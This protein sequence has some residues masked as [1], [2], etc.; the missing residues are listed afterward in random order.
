MATRP[1]ELAAGQGVKYYVDEDELVIHVDL[2]S[3]GVRSA[4]GKTVVIASSRGNVEV[5]P[6][7][8]LGLNIYR[9]TTPPTI[10]A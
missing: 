6:G 10:R 7:V 8:F 4:S 5:I 3:Q 2:R 9:K 1:Q